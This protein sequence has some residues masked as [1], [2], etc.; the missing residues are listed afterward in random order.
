MCLVEGDLRQQLIQF[1]CRL[2]DQQHQVHAQWA[3]QRIELTRFAFRY[4]ERSYRGI[5]I[6]TNPLSGEVA[7]TLSL[8][9]HPELLAQEHRFRAVMTDLCHR[10]GEESEMIFN[11]MLEIILGREANEPYLKSAIKVNPGFPRYMKLEKLL[12]KIKSLVVTSS[13]YKIRSDISSAHKNRSYF[14]KIYLNQDKRLVTSPKI[15]QLALA[16]EP[17]FGHRHEDNER[18]P[19]DR[20]TQFIK[21]YI[22]LEEKN[23]IEFAK[24]LNEGESEPTTPLV[25]TRPAQLISSDPETGV[26]V[27]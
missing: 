18:R 20:T 7:V 25:D 12:D 21:D 24:H 6:R 23:E 1:N 3:Y 8:H 17:K 22:E 14:K 10:V 16:Y 19:R 11:T 13:F 15:V 26:A 27:L 5:L 2:L 4:N 9:A